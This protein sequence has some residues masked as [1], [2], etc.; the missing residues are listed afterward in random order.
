MNLGQQASNAITLLAKIGYVF[1]DL[2]FEG[3][4]IPNADLSFGVFYNTSFKLAN[5]DGVNL[6]NTNI[7]N[8][9]FDGASVGGVDFGI[10]KYSI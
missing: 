5:I 8:S 7:I 9:T 4:Q 2:N 3:I 1:S 10:R 6:F